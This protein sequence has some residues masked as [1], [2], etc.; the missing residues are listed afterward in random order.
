MKE[1]LKIIG[2]LLAITIVGP[3]LWWSWTSDTMNPPKAEMSPEDKMLSDARW[4][5]Q[6]AI[7]DILHDPDSAE[8]GMRSGNW[9]ARWPARIDGDV[10]TVA[11]QF[12]ATNAIGATVLTS[13]RCSIRMTDDS[14]TFLELTEL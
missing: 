6:Q 10:V 1:A 13:W 11:P 12:R 3:F 5:C 4:A 8:W 9:Y 14:W 7:R 2:S